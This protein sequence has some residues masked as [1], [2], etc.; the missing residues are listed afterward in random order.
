MLLKVVLEDSASASLFT[1]VFSGASSKGAAKVGS[2]TS[3]RSDH[4]SNEGFML[5]GM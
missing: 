4:T 2:A 1:R 3:D 5:A